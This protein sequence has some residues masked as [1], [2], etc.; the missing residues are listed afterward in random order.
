MKRAAALK[1][2]VAVHAES[3]TMT[4]QL[5][6]ER[7]ARNQVSI[8][9]FLDSRPVVAEL[10]AIR[11]ALHLASETRCALHIVHVSCGKGVRLIAKARKQ[12]IDVSCETCPH[13]LTLTETDMQEMGAV[14]NCAPPLRPV[15][16]QKELWQSLLA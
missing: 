11:R 3:E 10:D 6:Q 1:L 14:A 2:L 15:N 8:R 5:A 13:Y 7:I 12:G 4:K 16:D 9:D